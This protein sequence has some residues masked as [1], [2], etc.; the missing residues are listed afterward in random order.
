MTPSQARVR[1]WVFDKALSGD[2][3]TEQNIHCLD[4]A[5]WYLRGRPVRAFGRS[6]DA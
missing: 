1:N 6:R 2:I 5:N 3:I 4:V